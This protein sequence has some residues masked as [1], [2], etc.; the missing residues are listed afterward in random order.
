MTDREPFLRYPDAMDTSC[1]RCERVV[2]EPLPSPDSLEFFRCPQ[3]HFEYSRQKGKGLTDRWLSPISLALYNVIFEVH[4][5][6]VAEQS[7]RAFLARRDTHN[8]PRMLKD[9]QDE[10]A[11]PRQNVRDIL[12]NMVADEAKLRDYLRRFADALEQALREV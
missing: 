2:L 8:L 3:C 1:L 4:P 5:G 12:P 10:L 7:A 11:R 6:D 9:I